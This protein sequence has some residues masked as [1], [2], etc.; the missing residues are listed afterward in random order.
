MQRSF[1]SGLAIIGMEDP[2]G[3]PPST[4]PLAT[5][6]IQ[7]TASVSVVFRLSDTDF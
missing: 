1:L 7:V 2:F 3:G 4:P 5:G 6:Q